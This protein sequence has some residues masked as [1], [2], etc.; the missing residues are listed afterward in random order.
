MKTTK[1]YP[2]FLVDVLAQ[3]KSNPDRICVTDAEGRNST[4]GDFLEIVERTS[5]YLKE[6][7]IGPGSFVVIN[8]PNSME[9]LA[10]EYG[11]WASGSAICPVSPLYPKARIDFI[12]QHCEAA[13]VVDSQII[14]DI[15]KAPRLSVLTPRS[16]IAAI[17]YTSGSTGTP[18]GVVHTFESL[19]HVDNFEEFAS[20]SKDDCFGLGAP[21][22]FIACLF[23]VPYLRKGARVRLFP[24]T[25][26]TDAALLQQSMDNDGITGT[27]LNPSA[28]RQLD[29]SSNKTLKFVLT[30]SERV[31]NLASQGDYKLTCV[32]G[33]TETSAVV[34]FYDIDKKYDNTPVGKP[35][36]DIQLKIME[37]GEI[38]LRGPLSP[39][40]YKDPQR[41]A[42][43]WRG[44]WFHTGD[45]G[46]EL[47]DGNVVYINRKDWMV[48]INGQR[49]ETGEIIHVMKQ[50]PG[51]LEAI[52]K[53]FTAA[54]GRQYIVGYYES[55]DLI[56][57]DALREF[58]AQRLA[59]YMIPSYFVRMRALPRNI[60]GKV[61]VGSLQ[62]PFEM[63]H[64]EDREIKAA[65][66]DVQKQLCTAFETALGI[67]PVSID[68][69]FFTLGGDSIRVMQMQN[70]CP[71]LR[72]SSDLIYRNR[73]VAAIAEALEKEKPSVSD[74]SSMTDFPLS[75]TQEGIFVECMQRQG[76]AAYNNPILYRLSD[77]IDPQRLAKACEIAVKAHPNVFASILTDENGNPVQRKNSSQDFSVK[78]EEMS[79]VTFDSMRPSLILPFNILKDRLFR[80]RVFKTDSNVWLF[81]D[82]HHIIF[83]GSSNVILL[84]DIEKAYR[85]EEV[86]K[87]TYTGFDLAFDEKTRLGTSFFEDCKQW[88]IN[89]FSGID[90]TTL[91]DPDC[92][93]ET[94][95][96]EKF[97]KDST[98]S[99]EA[100]FKAA[101]NFGVTENVLSLGAFGYMLGVCS[102]AMSSAFTTV[103]NGRKSLDTVRT[104]SM[105][106]KTLPVLCRWDASLTIGE[107]L[108]NVKDQLAGSMAYDLFSF[109]QICA[110]TAYDSRVIFTWQDELLERNTFCDLPCEMSSLVDNATGE[111][112]AVQLYKKN[113]TLSIRTEYRSNMYSRSYIESYIDCFENILHSLLVA[114]KDDLTSSIQ[115]VG[116]GQNSDLIRIGTGKP[117]TFNR[118]DTFVSLFKKCVSKYPDNIAVV[119]ENERITY[120]QLDE[121]SD[122]IAS[123]LVG[124]GVEKEDFVALMLPRLWFFP[125][126]Y[127]AC[128]KCGAAYVPI[129]YEYPL[130][131]IQYMLEDS[132]AKILITT[133]SIYEQKCKEGKINV[134]KVLFVDQIPADIAVLDDLDRAEPQGLAYMIYTSGT[135][136]KP[137]G[138]M[139]EHHSLTNF[140]YWFQDLLHT[141]PDTRIAEHTSF[142]FDG[143][144]CD[145]MV[146]LCF[147]SELHI[148]SSSI[149]KD[150]SQMYRYFNENGIHGCTFTT[151]LGIAMLKMYDLKLK[152]LIVGG[153]KLTPPSKSGVRL[154]NCYGPTEFT[155][156][157]SR[158]EVDFNDIPDNIPI[159]K[160]VPNTVSA[161]VDPLGRLLPRGLVGELVLIGSQ[162]SRGYWHRPDITEQRFNPCPFIPGEKMY[163]TGDL[164]KWNEDGDLLYYG[165]IDTQIK[166]RG[167]RIEL[168][169]IE[170]TINKYPLIRQAVV[171]VKEISG[172]QHLCAYYCSDSEIDN[173]D[174]RN[175]LSE[176]LTDYMVP[177][178]YVRLDSMPYTPNGKVDIRKLPLPEIKAEEIVGAQTQLEQQLL[179][180]TSEFLGNDAFGVTTNLVSMGMTSLGAISL[181]LLVEKKLDI[182]IS[183]AKM[184]LN[185]TIRQWAQLLGED[186]PSDEKA[187]E[188]RD[189]Y[190]LTDNQTGIYIDWEQHR[191]STQYNVPICFGFDGVD[192]SSLEK[193]AQAFIHAHPHLKTRFKIIDGQTCQARRDSEKIEISVQ[194][195]DFLPGKSFFQKRVRPFDLFGGPLCRIEIF[196]YENKSWLFVDVHHIIFDGTSESIFATELI[197]ALNGGQI[198]DENYTAFDYSLYYENWKK[199]EEYEKSQQYYTSLLD[200][201]VSVSVPSSGNAEGK[202]MGRVC[203]EVEREPVRSVCRSVGVTENAFFLTAVTEVLHRFTRESNIV[204]LTVSN[205]RSLSVL[206]RSTGMFVQTLPVASHF[207]P[208]SVSE[209]LT[210]MHHQVVETVSRDKYP[211]TKIVERNGVRTNILV[212]YQGDVLDTN[213]QVGGKAV[214]MT[215]LTSDTAKIPVSIN[216]VPGKERTALEFEYDKSLF[217]E[218][219]I[220]QLCNAVRSFAQNMAASPVQMQ[221]GS[222]ACVSA[223][224]ASKLVKI[225][226]GPKKE[227]DKSKTI[228][229]LFRLSAAKYPDD[230]AVVD[231]VGSLTYS[232]LDRKSD[233]LCAYILSKGVKKEDFVGLMFPRRKEYTIAFLAVFKSGCAYLPLDFEYPVDRLQYMLEDS[234]SRILIT[235]K[236]IY[237]NKSKEGSLNIDNV[238]F[239]DDIDLESPSIVPVNNAIPEGLAYMIYTSGTTGKPKGVMLEHKALMNLISWTTDLEKITRGSRVGHH[240]SFS[241][242][243]SIIDLMTPLAFGGQLHILGEDVRKDP[244]QMYKYLTDNKI[245]AL[246][247]STQ[248]GMLL[249]NSYDLKIRYMMMGGEKLSGHFSPDITVVNGYGP[250][251]FAVCSSYHILDPEHPVDNIPIGKA[252][253][254]TVSAI[255]DPYGELLPEGVAGELVLIGPQI[256][257]GYFGKDEITRKRF[258]PCPFIPGERMYHT[259]DLVRWSEDGELLF[260]G[261]IDTQVKLR[262]FRIE[263]GEI[264][265]TIAR[266]NGV[267]ASVAQVKEIGGVQHLCAYFTA[268]KKIDEALVKKELSASLTSYMVPDAIIQLDSMPLTPNGKIDL[269]AL[270]LP[271]LSGHQ[272]D[273]YEAPEGERESN[274]AQAFSSVLG[275][276]T[277]VGRNDSFFNLGGTSLLVMKVIVLLSEK[278]MTVTYGDLFKYPTPRTLTAF[279]DGMESVSPSGPSA[280]EAAQKIDEK[281]VIGEDGYD[282]SKINSILN[283]N[284]IE[285]IGELSSLNANEVG[286]VLLLGST[287][288][289]GIHV[290]NNLL[291]NYSGKVY[292]V[293]RAKKGVSCEGRLK[294][295]LMYY[296]DN[297]HSDLFGERLFIIEGDMTDDGVKDKLL[298]IKVDTVINCAANVKHFAAGD[299]IEKINLHGT[300]ILVD[301]CLKTGARLIHTST[302][303]VSGQMED[304]EPH[305]MCE[306]DLYFGQK[307]VTKYQTSKFSAER[308]ILEAVDKGLK[309]KIM[310]LGNLMPRFSDGE[311]QI[312]VE[313]NGFMSRM[314][315]YYLIGCIASSHLHNA[316]EFAPIDQTADAVITLSKT[317]DKFTVFHSFNN[318]TIYIDDVVAIMRQCGLPIEI[319]S[320]EVFSQRLNQSLKDDH[321]NPFITTLLAYGSHNNFVVNPP[322]LDFTVNVLNAMDWRWSITS[323]RYLRDTFDKLIALEYFNK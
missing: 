37:D 308:T 61:D 96:F 306:N 133:K 232:E 192:A 307:L 130:D 5:G 161:I 178:A 129:D 139:I 205:G 193:A 170:S 311:F 321:L 135:T 95:T 63:S 322:S 108:Q 52:A 100:F 51:V 34:C 17:F 317:P 169:E 257:R 3:C 234:K 314:R 219:D 221:L 258:V 19:S 12:T 214:E 246:S 13:L 312:N 53:G 59:P 201:A 67:S 146:S 256:A 20:A 14:N 238:I 200:G 265:S 27:F 33:M 72:L 69:D 262:G 261:R 166:L 41:S 58:L 268:S 299:E 167:F 295:Y 216:I 39:G 233:V 271:D 173:T 212:A 77:G 300:E 43:V 215:A 107:Y 99:A 318:H 26:M 155:V 47:P 7:E 127:V 23:T 154:I 172:L 94:I 229:D 191:D 89:T 73:T 298:S 119:D 313:N 197:Q 226:S 76:E 309:A 189:Y 252:V 183:S 1:S 141:G 121:S 64:F 211:F 195:L 281:P 6:K 44:G 109:S 74:T 203:A 75:K 182:K 204:I 97:E 134:S 103:Y 255:V 249:L 236:E 294:S 285:C 176:S 78:V 316:L 181:S 315:A 289:L 54:D 231:E 120:R 237:R 91:P 209:A 132:E 220:K 35:T 288:Y 230:I 310:R 2:Q 223:D 235:T 303:S 241:F 21:L 304:R 131:R 71:A 31:S 269:K 104:M 228:V 68:D 56:S 45:L 175:F 267:T 46:R 242:D 62:S 247:L 202:G 177:T 110:S 136:G 284:R 145:L 188:K 180:I 277:S 123:Y 163:R 272:T 225:G 147:G 208:R 160:A 28:L 48:K 84:E 81:T 138:V 87:E 65:Q 291:T 25:V 165:R 159:G 319:V 57:D 320:D 153:E 224:E 186:K 270:P 248:L 42:E 206:E 164:V 4:Y 251:E 148:L 301:Y 222:I 60:N 273:I 185:P 196:A 293:I 82:F 218:S 276:G 32:Y 9:Y 278:G 266:V 24:R 80:I 85:G 90:N 30:G 126:S 259:G 29:L 282:Y 92:F 275:T 98:I 157:S 253:P 113:G 260:M 198:E 150:L 11:V 187:F 283:N 152:Y 111:P 106:V 149:R 207:T 217:C 16:D 10:V 112:F 244:E 124:Q 156:A 287:G 143:S 171:A 263:L 168:G 240:P 137:K 254:N 290:L 280:D 179:D 239:I 101:L 213:L 105:L 158:Y 184:L 199:S 305:T 323:E 38:C 86:Q 151:Q 144:M 115:L 194:K 250:T 245:E 210:G 8:L 88:N 93:S 116:D 15:K 49:V 79:D 162:L 122:K 296:F 274:I 70:L 142:S 140:V 40:Y 117:L 279:L 297:T 83:D 128:F 114:S 264:E 50:M 118:E 292:C 36:Q 243:A 102:H 125:A 22:S 55:D 286:D 174:L 190:P 227:V 66:N 18:K 302:H